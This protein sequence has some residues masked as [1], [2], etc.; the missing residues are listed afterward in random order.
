MSLVSQLVLK[1]QE[2]QVGVFDANDKLRLWQGGNLPKSLEAIPRICI[3]HKRRA[4]DS[5]TGDLTCC[6]VI[7]FLAS[8]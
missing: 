1:D 2:D 6:G 3:E 8:M 4:E 5:I 7:V